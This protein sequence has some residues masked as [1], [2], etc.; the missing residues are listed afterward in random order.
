MNYRQYCRDRSL[1]RRMH[2]PTEGEIQLQSV[3]LWDLVAVLTR[4]VQELSEKVDQLC[5]QPK[6]GRDKVAST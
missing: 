6:K 5:P 2:S 3:Q 1:A 4:A